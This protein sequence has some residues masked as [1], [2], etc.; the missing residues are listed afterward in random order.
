MSVVKDL[1]DASHGSTIGRE[2]R[3]VA[4]ALLLRLAN[5]G[6]HEAK[7]AVDELRRAK[8]RK[9]PRSQATIGDQIE[10]KG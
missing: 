3:D 4:W 6:C 2:T 7:V 10:H 9:S 8:R 1:A 5:G